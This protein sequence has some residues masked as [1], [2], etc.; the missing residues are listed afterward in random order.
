MPTDDLLLTG[1]EAH[2]GPGLVAQRNSA[3]AKPDYHKLQAGERG[4]AL[5]GDVAREVGRAGATRTNP[6]FY[7]IWQGQASDGSLLALFSWIK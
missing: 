2:E 7:L 6:F 3:T 5:T 1:R 4:A